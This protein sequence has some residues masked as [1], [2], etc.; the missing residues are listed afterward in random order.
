MTKRTLPTLAFLAAF[1]L[2][3]FFFQP[4]TAEGGP[5]AVFPVTEHDVGAVKQGE[6][7]EYTFTVQNK[8]DANLEIL[9]VAPG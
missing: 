5:V 6:N 9:R 8:G 3:A 4:L 2:L 1:V 7:I